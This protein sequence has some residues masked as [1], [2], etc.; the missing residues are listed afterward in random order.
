MRWGFELDRTTEGQIEISRVPLDPKLPKFIHDPDAS[1][2]TA[3]EE[4]EKLPLRRWPIIYVRSSDMRQTKSTRSI[5]M[6]ISVRSRSS[7]C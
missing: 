7:M 5:P 3:L 4:L 2:N 1:T 6:A